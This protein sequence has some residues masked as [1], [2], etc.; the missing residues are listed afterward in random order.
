[1][2]NILILFIILSIGLLWSCKT[3]SKSQSDTPKEVNN[4]TQKFDEDIKIAFNETITFE[5]DMS[6]EFI[7]LKDSR[8]PKGVSCFQAGQ[9]T[10]V[11]NFSN[12]EDTQRVQLSV[13]GL[14]DAKC[15]EKKA[16]GNYIF[17]IKELNPYP[18]DGNLMSKEN[19]YAMIKITKNNNN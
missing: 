13:K 19:Y 8:C 10:V 18:E 15:G 9:G 5:N 11:L 14:C 16:Q 7:D 17:E 4:K 12:G 1:M 3:N 6:V 2:K